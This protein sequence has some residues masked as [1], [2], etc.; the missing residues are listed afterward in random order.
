M[1]SLWDLRLIKS[2]LLK[3]CMI[4]K[5]GSLTQFNCLAFTIFYEKNILI[6]QLCTKGQ[7]SECAT[8]E[9][10]RCISILATLSNSIVYH[11]SWLFVRD[12]WCASRTLRVNHCSLPE[13]PKAFRAK[14]HYGTIS[15]GSPIKAI[16][17]HDKVESDCAHI[18]LWIN[19]Y[20]IWHKHLFSTNYSVRGTGTRV[21]VFIK[22]RKKYLRTLV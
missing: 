17:R 15:E 10:Y 5:A 16:K 9:N 8:F 4:L 6:H 12:A 22:L 2:I 18:S 14:Y 3:V 19:R 20:K 7:R 11:D 1:D 21:S 13:L